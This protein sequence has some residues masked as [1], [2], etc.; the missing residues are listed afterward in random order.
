MRY[1]KGLTKETLKLL[2]RIYQQ[3]KY[4][5]V[6][7]RAHCIQLS[8]EGYK[9]SELMKI[10]KVSR[11]T[12]Y[13][14]FNNWEFSGLVGLYNR[15]GQGR[16]KLFEIHQ[17]EIIKKWVKETPKNLGLVPEKIHR[18]WGVTASKDT[19]KRVIKFVQMGWDRI[20]RRVGGEPVPEFYTQKV[21]ELEFLKQQEQIGKIE[22]RYVDETGFCLIPYIPI[23]FG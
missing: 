2:K 1:I 6:R 15:P 17:Q 12:I 5:Q 18:Q 20:K 14:W 7:Q 3:S 9:I 8:Y 16:Q 13:N 23:L 10:F 11:N 4:Y 19:I 22:I 21:K